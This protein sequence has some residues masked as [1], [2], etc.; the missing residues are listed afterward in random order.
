MN[1][2]GY[3]KPGPYA[4]KRSG[5]GHCTGRE[6]WGQDLVQ[7]GRPRS[8]ALHRRGVWSRALHREGYLGSRVLHR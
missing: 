2:E 5:P 7:R 4:G 3:L 1:R 8:R 6:V